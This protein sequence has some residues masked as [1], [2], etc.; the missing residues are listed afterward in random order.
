MSGDLE[1]AGLRNRDAT[2][3]ANHQ[4]FYTINQEIAEFLRMING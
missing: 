3:E 4:L 2:F 1:A